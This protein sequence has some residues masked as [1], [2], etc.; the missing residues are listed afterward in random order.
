MAKPDYQRRFIKRHYG[1]IDIRKIFNVPPDEM[2]VD[3]F[4]DKRENRYVLHTLKDY[5][6]QEGDV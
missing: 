1:V 5:D 4:Y 6:E 2:I 3:V